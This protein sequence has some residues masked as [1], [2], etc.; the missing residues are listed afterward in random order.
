MALQLLDII[1]ASILNPLVGVVH[2]ARRRLA[3]L[4]GLLQRAHR[5]P[6]GQRTIQGPANRLAREPIED[7]REK[8][9]L[10][11]QPDIG[12]ICDPQLVDPAQRHARCQVHVHRL[13]VLGIGGQDVPAVADRQQI[14]FPHNPQHP[15][16]IDHHS[17]AAQIRRDSPVA[18]AAMVRQH[19]LL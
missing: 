3:A 12:E 2:H 1:R 5:Y 8:H 10:R 16:V 6:S 19:D 14:V 13:L 18:V 11:P 15:F 17:L 7:H 9:E 4:D